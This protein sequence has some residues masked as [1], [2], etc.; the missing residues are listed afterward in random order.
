M[1]DGET[2][3]R[4]ASFQPPNRYAI[5][6][7]PNIS[8]QACFASHLTTLNPRAAPP[9]SLWR[10]LASFPTRGIGNIAGTSFLAEDLCCWESH[11]SNKISTDRFYRVAIL[12]LPSLC[13]C[14]L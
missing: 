7:S 9:G 11:Q 6:P 4:S 14:P 2:G 12:R 5:T 8:S 1:R 3:A 10:F 13:S